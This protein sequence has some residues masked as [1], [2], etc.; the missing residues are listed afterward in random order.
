MLIE[1]ATL[2][3]IV[4]QYMTQAQTVELK[5]INGKVIATP[6]MTTE[7][8]RQ[9]NLLGHLNIQFDENQLLAPLDDEEMQWWNGDHTDKYGIS[10]DGQS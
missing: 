2:P 6:I 8:D 1:L 3:P 7:Q 5:L 10:L 4:Q 9:P